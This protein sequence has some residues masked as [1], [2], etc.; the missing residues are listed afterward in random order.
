[1]PHISYTGNQLQIGAK[2]IELDYPVWDTLEHDDLIVVLLNPPTDEEVR[3]NIVAFDLNGE[4][5][6]NVDPPTTK[7]VDGD[8]VYVGIG[9]DGDQLIANT[10]RGWVCEIDPADGSVEPKRWTK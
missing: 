8:V 2:K 1:M 9:V 10:W 7:E 3:D 5:K 4:Q 6:W